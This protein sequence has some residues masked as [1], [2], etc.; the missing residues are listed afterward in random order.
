MNNKKRYIVKE[1]DNISLAS[2][3]GRIPRWEIICGIIVMIITVLGV[4]VTC[5]YIKYP[6]FAKLTV[7]IPLSSHGSSEDVLEY[8]DSTIG[9]IG[10]YNY[11]DM[12]ATVGYM[13][14]PSSIRDNIHIGQVLNILFNNSPYIDPGMYEGKIQSINTSDMDS[15]YIVEIN[16]DANIINNNGYTHSP[17]QIQSVA[18]IKVGDTR[19]STYLFHSVRALFSRE[20]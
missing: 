1:S 12:S 7:T 3:M 10:L 20:E 18:E 17:A 14:I 4:I 11:I 15:F 13:Y 2:S 5:F 8:Q 19:L 9:I 6:Q 16:F